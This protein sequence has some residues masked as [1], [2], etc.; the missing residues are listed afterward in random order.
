MQL[1]LLVLAFL[2]LLNLFYL[3]WT[4]LCQQSSGCISPSHLFYVLSFSA[5]CLLASLTPNLL[6]WKLRWNEKESRTYGGYRCIML[7]CGFKNWTAPRSCC[8]WEWKKNPTTSCWI[9]IF[10][11]FFFNSQLVRRSSSVRSQALISKY[12]ITSSSG[13]LFQVGLKKHCGTSPTSPSQHA[14]LLNWTLS[15]SF[16]FARSPQALSLRSSQMSM[17]SLDRNLS[18][19]FHF[20]ATSSNIQHNAKKNKKKNCSIQP[21]LE[22]ELREKKGNKQCFWMAPRCFGFTY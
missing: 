11:F 8:Y 17:D 14:L 3:L 6:P 19:T 7:R 18:L 16:G 4:H 15:L 5:H 21:V 1:F 12:F 22:R 9:L 13:T 2:L 10:F 20:I